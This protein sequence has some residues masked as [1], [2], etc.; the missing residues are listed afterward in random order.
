MAAP[1]QSRRTWVLTIRRFVEVAWARHGPTRY[2]SVVTAPLLVGLTVPGLWWAGCVVGAV[3]GV[4]IDLR[5]RATFARLALSLERLSDEALRRMIE[6]QIA[7][8][9]V[10][11]FAYVAPY[12]ALAFAP[13]P[14]PVIGLLFCAGAAVVCTS[15]HVMTSRMI[16]FTIPP[17]VIG[18]ALNGWAMGESWVG[19]VLGGL[20]ALIGLNGIIT[21]RAG[22]ASFAD[23]IAS[24]L[25]AEAAAETLEHRVKERTEQ[26][27]FAT[28]R[29]QAANKAK[30][31]FLANMSHELRTPV[32]AVIGYAEIIEE[33]LAIGEMGTA[34]ADLG[35]I[36]SSATHLL[37]LI[38]ELLDLSRI[39]AG[40]VDLNPTHLDLEKLL[41]ETMETVS[42]TIAKNGSRS[43]I[44]VAP[45]A[46]T[47]FADETRARQCVLNLLSNAAKFTKNG[48]IVLDAR[49]CRIGADPGVAIAVRDTG[50]GIASEDLQRLFQP[51][52]QVDN[53]K[54]RAHD[55]AGLGLVIT[56]R[57]ARAMGGDVVVFSEVGKGSTFTLYL[58]AR[59]TL[60]RAA[61]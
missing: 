60:E 58:P 47:A 46:D 42:P 6:R 44:S 38:N 49:R 13:Q 27:A 25:E 8:L 31:M 35:K 43:H 36:R 7:A 14:G 53:T 15:L 3:V 34:T 5:V 57:L 9:A 39:E 12:M 28:R 48:T 40:K 29:A 37:T 50:P 19:F 61:A 22:A 54:T 33:D 1:H 41:R 59:A 24:R 30:S 56:R 21:A 26:L 32:N 11:T 20:A 51:F 16:F 23:L 4:V 2:A 45:E 18:L 17:I 52:T 10:I 55:G